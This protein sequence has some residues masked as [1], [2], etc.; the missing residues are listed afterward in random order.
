MKKELLRKAADQFPRLAYGL[1][2][3][4]KN[5]DRYKPWKLRRAG[6]AVRASAE[7]RA[8]A[9]HS[10]RV[11]YVSDIPRIREVKLARALRGLGWETILLSRDAPGLD[12]FDAFSSQYRYGDAWEAL[13][14]A[15][16]LEPVAHHVFAGWSYHTAAA[17]VRHR[18]GKI[19]VDPYD[20]LE[21]MA[22]ASYLK[23]RYPGQTGLER[24]CLENAD[25]VCCRSLETQYLKRSRGYRYRGKRIFFPDFSLPRTS[26]EPTVKEEGIHVV[27]I[28]GFALEKYDPGF[29]YHHYL[30]L[31]RALAEDGVHFHIYGLAGVRAGGFEETYSDYF[32]L[33][34]ET[35]RVHVH[36]PVPLPQLIAEIRKFT[37]G[38]HVAG[39][40]LHF[41]DDD[42]ASLPT[43]YEYSMSNR[44]YDYFR[45]GLPVILF[46]GRF[47]EWIAS[48]L[49]VMVHAEEGLLREPKAWLEHRLPGPELSAKLFRAQEAVLP[50]THIRRLATYY[51]ALAAA[52][53]SAART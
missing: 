41:V 3:L 8:R 22:R 36:R 40:E 45:A 39:S 28:G 48:R 17:F 47:Q 12:V 5:W 15:S 13:T 24:Y 38:L 42:A 53:G 7:A 32:E 20:I 26:A 27:Q 52:A 14:L 9:V 29:K 35:G 16:R 51:E 19:V 44:V 34:R 6:A 21:G 37:F 43:R 4:W 1:N 25:G 46:K 33:A 10:R 2:F 50:E 11:V 49:G 23:R 18:P 31:A 30:K